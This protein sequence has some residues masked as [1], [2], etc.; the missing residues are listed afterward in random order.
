MSFFPSLM[1]DQGPSVP[2]LCPAPNLV[3]GRP[4]P[5]SNWFPSVA[6][7]PCDAPAA[8]KDVGTALRALRVIHE[9]NSQTETQM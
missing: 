4:L 6:L 7:A 3:M 2:R 8:A 1:Q 9:F 5:T